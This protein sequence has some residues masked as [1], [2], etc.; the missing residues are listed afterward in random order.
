MD[1]DGDECLDDDPY[2]APSEH[3]S[4][5]TPRGSAPASPSVLPEGDARDPA[6]S[7]A[8]AMDSSDAIASTR[9]ASEDAA[10]EQV[11]RKCFSARDPQFAPSE[12]GGPLSRTLSFPGLGAGLGRD[13]FA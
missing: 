10:P 3:D 11:K 2:D 9:K 1:E 8:D 12:L 4:Q 7:A 6:L 5:A 13:M